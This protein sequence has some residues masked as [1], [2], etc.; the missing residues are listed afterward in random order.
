METVS[1]SC[2]VATVQE[3]ILPFVDSVKGL[4]SVL[5]DDAGDRTRRKGATLMAAE[6]GAYDCR[7]MQGGFCCG[8]V[9]VS[10]RNAMREDTTKSV[11]F[12]PSTMDILASVGVTIC[13]DDLES[14]LAPGPR[15]ALH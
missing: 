1:W 5:T 7:D 8:E 3:T 11:V 4:M 10:A 14:T 12:V 2:V 15:P 9:Q 6:R 13:S